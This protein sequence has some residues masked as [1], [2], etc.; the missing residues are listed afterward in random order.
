MAATTDQRELNRDP[1]RQGV[2]VMTIF[3]AA[4]AIVGITGL[5]PG[6]AARTAAAAG[7][8]AVAVAV[9]VVSLRW[10]SRPAPSGARGRRVSP[11]AGQSFVL[12]NI[13]QT[14]AIVVAVF[15]LVKAGRPELVAAAV[16]LVVGLHFL[17]LA[18]IFDVAPYRWTGTLLILAALAG[19]AA[20][21]YGAP[22]A[23]TVAVVT[24][25]AAAVLW[26]TSL[27][28]AHRG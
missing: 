26:A 13:A 11:R 15:A 10:R 19:T 25:P 23:T 24:L 14:V 8:A 18:R 9:A 27:L 17:P 7:A 5:V 28:V 6:G 22:A 12:I 16:C 3:G 20:F 1:V 2:L 21:G 4:W